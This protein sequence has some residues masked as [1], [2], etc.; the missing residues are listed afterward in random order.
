MLRKAMTMRHAV[1]L[2]V[3][4]VLGSGIL[5]LPGLAARLAGP[6]SLPAWA[7]LSLASYPFAEVS[8]RLPGRRSDV[9]RPR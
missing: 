1:T 2:Y 4:S 6:G 8:T 9:M 7:V 3:S 5:V